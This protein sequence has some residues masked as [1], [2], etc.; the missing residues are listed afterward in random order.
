MNCPIGTVRSRI[1]RAR[2]AIAA[3]LRPLLD[4]PKGQEMVMERISSLMDGEL[5]A[6]QAGQELNR[7]KNDPEARKT[8]DAFHLI[9]DAMRGDC[10]VSRDFSAR[11]Q[12]RLDT[13]PTVLAPR[14]STAR[15]FATY[16]WPA[17]ASFSAVALVGWMAFYSPLAPQL[18]AT[19]VA[20]PAT[21][22]QLAVPATPVAVVAP[23]EQIANVPSEGRMNEYLM[24]HQEFSPSTAIQ[25]GGPLHPYG[26]GGTA[27]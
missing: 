7:L 25:G 27:A 17:A 11:L 23:P 20:A 10:V 16:A 26:L 24:A 5:D 22:A 19:Q 1:F 6:H 8:W 2:E 12:A 21:P 13:E 15:P 18:V 14:R 4:T 9:G 3:K